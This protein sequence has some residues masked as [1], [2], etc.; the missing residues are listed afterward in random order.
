MKILTTADKKEE[1]FLK[2]KTKPVELEA[3]KKA[4][5]NR[6]IRDMQTVM[7]TADGVGLS[8]NQV[9]LNLRLFVA[10]IPAD[11]GR[12]KKFYAIINPEIVKQSEEKTETEE[13]CLSVPETFGV[14]S[15]PEKIVI[16]G[17]D[18]NGKKIKIK[19]WGL[20]ARVFQHEIDHLNGILFIDKAKSVQK[21]IPTSKNI[22]KN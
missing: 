17:F 8:A 12:A 22:A 7:R 16:A 14:V 18:R 6:L 11:Q 9:G 10:E 20:L 13:G 1:K 21:I 19:A 3:W 4:D 5:S 15:R 2:S